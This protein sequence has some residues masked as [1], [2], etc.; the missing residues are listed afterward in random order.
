AQVNREIRQGKHM[1]LTFSSIKELI[2]ERVRMRMVKSRR[3]T[4]RLSPS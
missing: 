2:A 4:S 3:Y 1:S